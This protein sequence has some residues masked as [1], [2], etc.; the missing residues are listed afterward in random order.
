MNSWQLKQIRK[1]FIYFVGFNPTSSE[2]LFEVTTDYDILLAN[3]NS[4]LLSILAL[5]LL[6]PTLQVFFPPFTQVKPAL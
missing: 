6:F 1:L 5:F 2:K 4:L 3:I